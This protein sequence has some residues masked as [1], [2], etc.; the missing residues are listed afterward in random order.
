[1]RERF[2]R[3]EWKKRILLHVLR[4]LLQGGIRQDFTNPDARCCLQSGSRS[5][6][7]TPGRVSMKGA[8]TGTAVGPR[9]WGHPG[10]GPGL[11]PARRV[12]VTRPA[13]IGGC[14]AQGMYLRHYSVSDR[15]IYP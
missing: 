8:H 14:S 15:L 2:I 7:C 5:G 1:M 9:S 13:G 10:V 6:G 3:R 11:C 4:I 12:R